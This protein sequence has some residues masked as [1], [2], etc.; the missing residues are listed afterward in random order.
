MVSASN[1]DCSFHSCVFWFF[2]RS[3]LC[4]LVLISP[5]RSR[6]PYPLLRS[7]TCLPYFKYLLVSSC[8]FISLCALPVPSFIFLFEDSAT[9]LRAVVVAR[10]SEWEELRMQKQPQASGSAALVRQILVCSLGFRTN[11]RIQYQQKPVYSEAMSGKT[12]SARKTA[13]SSVDELKQHVK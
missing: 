4:Y 11:A 8:L 5:F 1:F 13:R 7:C 6:L 2:L 9:L 12:A 10:A 3:N